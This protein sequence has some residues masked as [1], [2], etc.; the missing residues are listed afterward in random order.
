MSV[1]ACVGYVYRSVAC[2]CVVGSVLMCE[3]EVKL[4]K[5]H[6]N[7]SPSSCA[8]THQHPHTCPSHIHITHTTHDTRHMTHDTHDAHDT[9]DTHTTH[10]THTTHSH[11]THTYNIARTHVQHT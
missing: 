8:H 11:D 5:I 1:W 2:M 6:T 9:H 3:G 7:F 4:L 10:M